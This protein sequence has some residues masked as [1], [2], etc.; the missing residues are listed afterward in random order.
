MERA[1]ALLWDNDGILVDTE[2]LYMGVTRDI[3]AE[4]GV[5]LSVDEFREISLERGQSCFEL[6]RNAGFE[7]VEIDRLRD[8]RDAAYHARVSSG[9]PLMKGA[10]ETLEALHGKIP[11]AIV[12]SSHP[13]DL[14][15]IH[16]AHALEVFFDAVVA[17]GDYVR[18]K[19]HPDPYLEGAARLG[20][21][22]QSCVAVEDTQ[23]GMRAALA[24]GMECWVIPHALSEDSD[25]TGA[26]RILD[27]I[28][29]VE[30]LI[31]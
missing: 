20:V 31:L 6:V 7:E 2:P 17:S 1:K 21:D 22:P 12:T 14:Y 3:M 24:A 28:S 18:H 29:E 19:P 9:V 16:R 13:E 11:M 27:N 23:R 10:R 30:G 26:H 4:V 8:R 15:A 25:F 5:G